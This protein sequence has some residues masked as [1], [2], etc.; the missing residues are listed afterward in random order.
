M[1]TLVAWM[2]SSSSASH[3][4]AKDAVSDWFVAWSIFM[5]I[6]EDTSCGF[7]LRGRWEGMGN[8]MVDVRS[9]GSWPNLV[10]LH[11]RFRS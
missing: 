10:S 1:S 8:A 3:E 11:V 6:C 5:R 4:V 9:G 2:V 7:G